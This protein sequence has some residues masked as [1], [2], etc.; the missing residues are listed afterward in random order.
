MINA[1]GRAIIIH[2]QIIRPM[3]EGQDIASKRRI[4]LGILARRAGAGRNGPREGRL[5]APGTWRIYRAQQHLQNMQ[6]TAGMKT[7]GMTGNTGGLIGEYSDF[8]IDVPA[9]ETPR[10]QELHLPVYHYICEEIEK[11]IAKKLIN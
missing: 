5:V 1:N 8:L 3:G 4:W 11:N 10:I 7:I 2:Q 6:R 9:S